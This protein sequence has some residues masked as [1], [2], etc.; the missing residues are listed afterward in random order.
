MKC[1]KIKDMR[2]FHK[3]GNCGPSGNPEF[4]SG[5]GGLKYELLEVCI[6]DLP[7]MRLRPRKRQDKSTLCCNIY[8]GLTQEGW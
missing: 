1:Q 8:K 4:S 5:I 3:G 6:F 7:H 2:V